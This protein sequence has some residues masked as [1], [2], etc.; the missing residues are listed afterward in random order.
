MLRRLLKAVILVDLVAVLA[1]LAA[2]WLLSSRGGPDSDEIDLA[3]VL[4]GIHLRSSST[5]FMGGST[6]ALFGGVVL[7]LRRATLGPTGADLEVVTICGGTSIITPPDWRVD[8][9]V[10]T[11]IGGVDLSHEQP[12]DTEAPSLHITARTYLG[13]FQVESR[14]RLEAVS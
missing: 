10:R 14:P 8:T 7:D 4:E 12:S 3:A 11:W 1:A 9:D 13:G 6:L 2:R 5:A